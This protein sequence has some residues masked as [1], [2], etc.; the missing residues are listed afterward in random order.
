M[1]QTVTR[2][3]QAVPAGSSQAA[4]QTMPANAS[5]A[6][7]IDAPAGPLTGPAT[8]LH[9]YPH[10]FREVIE[11]TKHISQCE[12]A[13]VDWFPNRSDFLSKKSGEYFSEAIA[14]VQR[15]PDG[16]WPQY[17][18]DLGVLIWEALITW[19]SMLKAKACDL[20]KRYYIFGEDR[21]PDE[22]KIEAEALIR[23]SMFTWNGVN[24]E[25]RAAIDEIRCLNT[26]A[27]SKIYVNFCSMQLTINEDPKHAAKMKALQIKWAAS[28]NPHVNESGPIIAFNSDFHPMLD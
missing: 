27:N 7:P 14:E 20:V 2:A 16:Y 19:R 12:C 17:K 18:K 13:L 4:S 15:V 10:N 26:P 28:V 9:A 5:Q 23:G 3:P 22:N 21:S 8:K 25:L 24:D 1:P 11:R 6:M